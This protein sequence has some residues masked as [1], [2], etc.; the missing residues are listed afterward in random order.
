[1]KASKQI[2]FLIFILTLLGGIVT[3]Q[4]EFFSL[5]VLMSFLFLLKE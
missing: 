3:G 5:V 2:A 1:M 4:R